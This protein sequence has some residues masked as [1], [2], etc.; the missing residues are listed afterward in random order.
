MAINEETVNV[1]EVDPFAGP[2]AESSIDPAELMQLLMKAQSQQ[3]PSP[4]NFDQNFAKYRERLGSFQPR[5]ASSDIFDLASELGAGILASQQQGGRNPYVGIGQGFANLS[6]RL[7]NEDKENAAADQQIGM[8]A[9]QLALQDEQRANDFLNQVK[10]MRI[11]AANKDH[12]YQRVEWDEVDPETGE[13]TVMAKTFTITDPGERAQMEAIFANN[14]GREVDD[15]ETEIN[16]ETPDPQANLQNK[17]A[18]DEIYNSGKALAEE[19]ASSG[20]IIDQVSEAW[21]L[22]N[23]AKQAGGKFGPM[24][25]RT[26]GIREFISEMGLGHLLDAEDAIGSQKALNQLSMSFVMAI[27]SQTKGAISEKE[28][29]LFI[30]A[31]PTLGATFDGFMQQLRLMQKIAYRKKDFY[32]DYL[33]ELEKLEEEGLDPPAMRIKLEQWKNNYHETNPLLDSKDME[34]LTNAV[35]NPSYDETAFVPRSFRNEVE[36]ALRT[37]EMMPLVQSQQDMDELE[38]GAFYRTPDGRVWKKE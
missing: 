27:I 10:L 22:A 14:N 37:T 3:Q 4:Q 13:T 23:R 30:A 28:M 15:P 36:K 34:V 32:R 24:S 17:M 38:K 12:A 11:E 18:L 35:N 29:N 16:I 19:A 6:K 5:A 20:A 1:A 9:F 33:V 7:R 21:L 25:Y 2:T 31:S 26:L 8:Q